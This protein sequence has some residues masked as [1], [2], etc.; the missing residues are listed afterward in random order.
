MGNRMQ[1][2]VL[3]ATEQH[4]TRLKLLSVA[5][6]CLAA[7]STKTDDPAN[8]LSEQAVENFGLS[9]IHLNDTYRIGAVE[10]GA[11]GGFGRVVTIVKE[12]QQ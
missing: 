9:F 12:L 4:M 5:L 8:L 2:Y 7:C 6:L 3:K 10:S 11:S 1:P